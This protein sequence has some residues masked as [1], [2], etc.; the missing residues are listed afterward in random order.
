MNRVYENIIQKI[1]KL[2]SPQIQKLTKQVIDI[3]LK[4]KKKGKGKL[5]N[6]ISDIKE[7]ETFTDNNIIFLPSDKKAIFIGDLHGDFKA[8]CSILEKIKGDEYLIFLGD[9]TD[10]GDAQIKVLNS[11]LMLKRD[12]PDKVFLLRG[13]HESEE[14]NEI[15]GFIQILQQ[16][17]PKEYQQIYKEYIKLYETLPSVLITENKI[18]AVHGGIPN[19]PISR[20]LD[21]NSDQE[22][23]NQVCWNDPNSEISGFAQNLRGGDTRT[24]GKDVFENFM[25]AVG[26]NI[27]ITGH[28]YLKKGYKFLFDDKFITIFS[29]FHSD[30]VKN[31]KYLQIDLQ[32]PILKIKK[33][34]IKNINF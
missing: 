4:E 15:Y 23:I 18:I 29:S 17:F 5:K 33:N 1:E 21:L 10:R 24:F 34:M 26:A 11:V 3:L 6:K 20:L 31:P 16:K 25:K 22:K 14:M 28:R 30:Y 2:T 13:N 27:M 12:Y 8:L 19:K 32:K 7:K 9:Y